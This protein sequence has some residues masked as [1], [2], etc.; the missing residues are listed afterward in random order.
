MASVLCLFPKTGNAQGAEN[1]ETVPHELSNPRVETATFELQ[2]RYSNTQPT[3]RPELPKSDS[4]NGVNT[5]CIN[6]F[7]NQ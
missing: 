5:L 3:E 4:F 7:N 6:M 2:T 1:M